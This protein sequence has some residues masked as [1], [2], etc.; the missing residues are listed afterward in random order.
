[1]KITQIS[2]SFLSLSAFPFNYSSI[3]FPLIFAIMIAQINPKNINL[4][5][6]RLFRSKKSWSFPSRENPSSFGSITSSSSSSSYNVSTSSEKLRLGRGVADLGTPK[7]I[8][9]WVSGDWSN[10]SADIQ[11]ESAPNISRWW[12]PGHP[13]GQRGWLSA[14]PKWQRIFFLFFFFWKK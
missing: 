7:N 12:W 4:N 10:S 13:Y 3:L 11:F 6:K 8:M 2:S 1:M 5:P 14:T 9:P